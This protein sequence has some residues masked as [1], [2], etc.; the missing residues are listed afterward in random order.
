MYTGWNKPFTSHDV[1]YLSKCWYH[2]AN[3][4][5]S[6]FMMD[7]VLGPWSEWGISA[8][9]NQ[10]EEVSGFSIIV[11]TDVWSA[12]LGLINGANLDVKMWPMAS[13]L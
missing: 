9:T 13:F 6:V 4:G 10:H 2:Y 5:I 3:S 7:K 11:A 8:T 12:I 1:V